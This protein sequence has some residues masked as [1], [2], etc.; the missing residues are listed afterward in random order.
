M[1]LRKYIQLGPYSYIYGAG[2][3]CGNIRDIKP[4]YFYDNNGRLQRSE[5]AGI[6]LCRGGADI[7]HISDFLGENIRGYKQIKKCS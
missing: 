6:S 3:R 5:F 1:A 4:G 7:L 2:L